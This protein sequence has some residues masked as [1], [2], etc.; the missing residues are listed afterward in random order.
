MKYCVKNFER[1]TLLKGIGSAAI[2]LPFTRLLVIGDTVTADELPKVD[3]KSS[4]AIS[5]NYLH[6]ASQSTARKD[7][8]AI[9][10]NCALYSGD[11]GNEWGNCSIFPG[12]VVNANGW[13]SAWVPRPS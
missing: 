2:V 5:L 7:E 13:C 12:K 1:R 6:D 3:E 4:M 10:D 8:S 9:C 11:G